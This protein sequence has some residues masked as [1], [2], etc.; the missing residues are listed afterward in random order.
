MK[1]IVVY[2]LVCSATDADL[3]VEVEQ[4]IVHGL[5][6]FGGPFIGPA[7]DGA[8]V[9]PAGQWFYQAVVEYSKD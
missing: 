9:N 5:Q 1:K 7:P 4:A 8:S 2:E 6:P 3:E